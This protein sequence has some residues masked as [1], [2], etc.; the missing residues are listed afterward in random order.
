MKL[1]IS[2]LETE[3][4]IKYIKS[5]LTGYLSILLLVYL[6]I[7]LPLSYAA[8][9][10][11]KSFWPTFI[12]LIW[13]CSC[14]F[15][16]WYIIIHKL[17]KKK[18]GNLFYLLSLIGFILLIGLTFGLSTMGLFPIGAFIP[19]IMAFSLFFVFYMVILFDNLFLRYNSY[20][21]T[22]IHFVEESANLLITL[23]IYY[24]L[25]MLMEIVG[26][27]FSKI[28][29]ENVPTLLLLILKII[30]TILF[31]YRLSDFVRNI[32]INDQTSFSLE[33]W[34][35]AI[36]VTVIEIYNWVIFNSLDFWWLGV[37]TFGTAIFYVAQNPTKRKGSPLIYSGVIIFLLFFLFHMFDIHIEIPI[38]QI[39]TM[40]VF[41]LVGMCIGIV[42]LIRKIIF[43]VKG[44]QVITPGDVREACDEII[45]EDGINFESLLHILTIFT[46]SKHFD[47]FR[48]I[49][50]NYAIPSIQKKY[51]EI[52]L[53]CMEFYH[54]SKPLEIE[55]AGGEKVIIDNGRRFIEH[56]RNIFPAVIE[57]PYI[58]RIYTRDKYIT[59]YVSTD[60]IKGAK[61]A[62]VLYTVKRYFSRST[63]LIV[64]LFFFL[65]QIE[66]TS[67][68]FVP[69][70]SNLSNWHSLRI[71]EIRLKFTEAFKPYDDP[72][73]KSDYAEKMCDWITDWQ[74]HKI[75]L[76][77]NET[78]SYEASKQLNHWYNILTDFH[79]R[80]DEISCVIYLNRGDNYAAIGN[81]DM[82]IG[83]YEYA[84]KYTKNIEIKDIA[85]FNIA[86]CHL[87]QKMIDT[88]ICLLQKVE[89]DSDYFYSN[90]L[91]SQCYF[92][93][94]QFARVV[95]I[96]ESFPTTNLNA[97]DKSLL[98]ESYYQ[99][100]QNDKAIEIFQH[101]VDEGDYGD[102]PIP[103]YISN[104]RLGIYYFHCSEYFEAAYFLYGALSW[105]LM[106]EIDIP[107][108]VNLNGVLVNYKT[109]VDTIFI[110]NRKDYRVNL[111][112]CIYH[113]Y[114]HASD[115]V[116]WYFERHLMYSPQNYE[117]EFT[118]FLYTQLYGSEENNE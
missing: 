110:Q 62:R 116:M 66:D 112:Y 113:I 29:L 61:P 14:L 43:E 17:A 26:L 3:S 103:K 25:L 96:L 45:K 85:Q 84:F 52:S 86:T 56:I 106:K 81:Y 46:I 48:Q 60:I 74:N 89:N 71:A 32:E 31:I 99:M 51:L 87:S 102:T 105:N 93:K 33:T 21:A 70:L 95:K 72:K 73:F 59:R 91:L 79:D 98:A 94:H 7:F 19:L 115:S 109:S 41:P 1:S 63:V 80:K 104:L 83:C 44:V 50:E 8:P 6:V 77:D 4:I 49:L 55:T 35:I 22:S 90:K 47:I 117:E 68:S 64:I 107:F 101:I 114:A 108:Q 57:D 37:F 36:F 118:K 39:V 76:S 2:G 28:I 10:F 13:T 97:V 69:L 65:T 88:V 20:L 18:G 9:S 5:G 54:R 82:A 15:G 11:I 53:L 92:T 67:I 12:Y 78:L 42:T 23:G 16:A 24:I 34:L 38:F 40:I 30:G 27:F 75:A 100:G 111:W 58:W